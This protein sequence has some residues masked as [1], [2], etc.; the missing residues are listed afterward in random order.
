MKNLDKEAN[1]K[2]KN[3]KLSSTYYELRK[4]FSNQKGTLNSEKK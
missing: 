4:K 2:A 3:S 1:W